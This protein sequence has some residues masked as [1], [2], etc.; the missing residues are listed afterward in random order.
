MTLWVSG[1]LAGSML[2]IVLGITYFLL[3]EI[4]SLRLMNELDEVYKLRTVSGYWQQARM[5]TPP[6]HWGRFRS[7]LFWHR[8]DL[9]A[10]VF[11][12]TGLLFL[13]LAI[14]N[15]NQ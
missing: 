2:F 11:T 5:P 15:L 14:M 4:S 13:Y 8:Y 12:A 6:A 10:F 1:L 7:Y 9:A 3:G